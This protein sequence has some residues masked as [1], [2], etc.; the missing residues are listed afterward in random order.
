MN[1]NSYQGLVTIDL[2]FSFGTCNE[3][4][5]SVSFFALFSMRPLGSLN[6]NA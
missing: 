1:F 6:G 5:H 3:T 2:L 4:I